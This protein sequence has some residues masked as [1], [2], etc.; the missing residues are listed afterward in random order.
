M[1]NEEQLLEYSFLAA[2]RTHAEMIR[3]HPFVDGNGR[4]ARLATSIFL[5]DVGL[6][7]GTIIEP[8]K[9][10]QY[11]AAIDRAIDEGEPGDLSNILARGFVLQAARRRGLR[12]RE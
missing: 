9:K 12:S 6:A 3:I 2:A 8:S 5:R 11:I 7:C 4:W 10:R 1:K